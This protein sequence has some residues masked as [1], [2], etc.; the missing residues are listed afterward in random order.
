MGVGRQSEGRGIKFIVLMD[1]VTP[2]NT[3][4]TA[5]GAGGA[6]STELIPDKR[7]GH[8]FCILYS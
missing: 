1:A 2:G 6:A 5:S 8:L 4:L 3:C 7:P